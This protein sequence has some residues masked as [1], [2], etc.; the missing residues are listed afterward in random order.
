MAHKPSIPKGTRD[1]LPQDVMRRNFVIHRIRTEF[2]R[3]GFLPIQTPAMEK[4]EVLLGKYGDEGDRLIFKIL[5]SGEKIRKANSDA[6]S[7]GDLSSF[8]NSISEKALRYDLTVPFARFVVQNQNELLFPFKRYQI[9][10]VWRA[11]RPQFG[12]FQEF[13]QCDADVVGSD[14]IIQEIEF[15]HLFDAAFDQLQIKGATIRI[16]HRGILSGIANLIGASDKLIP[17]TV[18]LDKLDKIGIKGVKQEMSTKGIADKAINLLLPIMEMK[19]DFIQ[20]LDQLEQVLVQQESSRKA[21]ADLRQIVSN[22]QALKSLSLEF[23]V[24]LARGL[25]YYTGAIFEVAAP[26]EVAIGSVGAGGRYD[27]LTAS[28]GMKD[29]SGIGIS[30]GLDRICLLMEKLKLFPSSL[31]ASLDILVLNFGNDIVLDLLPYIDQLRAS[32]LRVMIYPDHVKLKKQL[33]YA[34]Q[35]GVPNVLI[36]GTEEKE[37]NSIIVKNMDTHTQKKIFLTQL[38]TFFEI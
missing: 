30:F 5:N 8:S 13:T 15:V 3:F 4:T 23:D 24:T 31:D 10:S 34:D 17:F 28:F 33:T 11:D 6:L 12:R 16:N 7:E 37:L 2:E 38:I 22:C 1:F 20:K 19:G 18:A 14:S 35:L 26:K 36:Y 21:L 25:D 29:M 27:N 32:N 9:Q